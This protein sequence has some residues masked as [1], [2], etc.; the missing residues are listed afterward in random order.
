MPKISQLPAATTAADADI[1]V[2]VQ[3]GATKNIALSVLKESFGLDAKADKVATSP[4]PTG[5][6]FFDETGNLVMDVDGW[7][8]WME[9]L[10][11]SP[12]FYSIVALT[13]A[14][15]DSLSPVDPNT[16]Y[17]IVEA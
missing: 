13:Q 6:A 2:L 4:D 1:A 9:T 8:D 10:V 12:D 7:R 14:E 15:Y 3:G 11:S 16:L 17:V 5:P